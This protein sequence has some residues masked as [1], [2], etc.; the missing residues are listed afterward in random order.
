VCHIF[1]GARTASLIQHFAVVIV[2]P[3]RLVS[4]LTAAQKTAPRRLGDAFCWTAAQASTWTR[5]STV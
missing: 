5:Q 1:A 2:E 4:V 3:Y